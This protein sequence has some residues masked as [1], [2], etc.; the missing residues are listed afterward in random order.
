[1]TR[2]PHN[3][4][5]NKNVISVVIPCFRVR[6]Q[7]LN[8][9]ES[10][11]PEVSSIVVVDDACPENT[12]KYVEEFCKDQRVKVLF[13]VVNEGVGGATIAGYRYLLETNTTIVIKI[14]GDGQMDAGNICKMSRPL[15][16]NLA[17]YTKGNRFYEPEAIR[18]M[19]KVRI[20]GNLILSFMTKLSSG[21]YQ[22]FDPNNGFTAIKVSLLAN[23]PLDKLDK[24]YFFES[25]MLFRVGISNGRVRDI[26]MHSI[27]GEE[28][29]NLR[30]GKVLF[31]FPVKH[32]KN[33]VKRVAYNYYLKDFN[34][35]S[36]ELPT[37]VSLSLFGIILGLESW[38]RNAITGQ[39][40]PPGTLILIAMGVLVGVQLLL[41]FFSFDTNAWR[42]AQHQEKFGRDS[43]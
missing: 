20:L 11:G 42:T 17:D 3:L 43:L 7:I 39:P 13:N 2:E 41:A 24:R 34:L 15:I 36:I 22:V 31:E 35:A 38:I 6:N 9:L 40:T 19:P 12:G 37:G 16:E 30:I 23:I 5:E 33:F 8:V 27:Y 25:D 14:D 18:R 1:M 10:I 32:F 26:P 21:Q 28:K 29:S 4:I